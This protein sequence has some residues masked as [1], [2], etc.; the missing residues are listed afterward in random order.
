MP[1]SIV[2]SE[3]AARAVLHDIGYGGG[4]RLG[5]ASSIRHVLDTSMPSRSSASR[6]VTWPGSLRCNASRM[7][8]PGTGP[9]GADISAWAEHAQRCLFVLLPDWSAGC[10]HPARGLLKGRLPPPFP[11]HIKPH[12]LRVPHRLRALRL[13]LGG[14]LVL[15]RAPDG[16][17]RVGPR[18]AR[19]ARPYASCAGLRV[20]PVP[21]LRIAFHAVRL[22]PGLVEQHPRRK[23]AGMGPA[24]PWDMR[25]HIMAAKNTQKPA[26]QTTRTQQNRQTITLELVI[27]HA[28]NPHPGREDVQRLW[29][30]PRGL[31]RRPGSD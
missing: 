10:G 15:G 31:A 28:P 21:I 19:R 2:V 12:K 6:G 1:M 5:I 7:P 4:E 24:E 18:H 20:A 17:E 29:A 25:D 14:V 8:H 13:P 9:S 22:L 30:R 27:A 16:E 26:Q 11:Y 3:P 23:D